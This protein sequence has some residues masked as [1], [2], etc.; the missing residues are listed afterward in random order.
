M[1]QKNGLGEITMTDQMKQYIVSINGNSD[2]AFVNSTVEML[3]AL[4][5]RFIRLNYGKLIPN[6]DLTQNFECNSCGYE[7]DM[8]VPFTSDFFWPE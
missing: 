7:Q 6:V 2:R 8:E 5:A 3:P 4:D 1:R